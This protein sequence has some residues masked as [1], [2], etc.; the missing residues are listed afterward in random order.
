VE[1]LNHRSDSQLPYPE[2]PRW[3]FF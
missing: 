1:P 3:R 2:S